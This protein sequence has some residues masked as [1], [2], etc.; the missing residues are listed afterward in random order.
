[1][2]LV[3]DWLT[4]P[5]SAG[6][7]TKGLVDAIRARNPEMSGQRTLQMAGVI[8]LAS[9]LVF[10]LLN[11]SIPFD[12]NVSETLSA[13]AAVIVQ[14]IIAFLSAVGVTELRAKGDEMR[15]EARAGQFDE[16]HYRNVGVS[17][18]VP[19]ELG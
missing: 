6:L 11:Q 19:E 13:V 5:L 3:N 12:G 2:D 14:A 7:V 10:A 18:S 8:A 1:M 17:P 9:A 4:G 16:D 15:R